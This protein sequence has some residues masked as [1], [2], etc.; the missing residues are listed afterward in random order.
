[1]GDRLHISA[2]NKDNAVLGL[3]ALASHCLQHGGLKMSDTDTP[4][5]RMSNG[6][7]AVQ[8]TNSEALLKSEPFKRYLL[9]KGIVL[10]GSL[11]I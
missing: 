6:N 10:S 9:S 4:T 2:F 8:W 11:L 7:Y 1:M 3:T 5:A